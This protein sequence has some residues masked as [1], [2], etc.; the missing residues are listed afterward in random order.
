MNEHTPL[1][2]YLRLIFAIGFAMAGAEARGRELVKP[3]D[4]EEWYHETPNRVLF[5]LYRARFEHVLAG[6]SSEA[7]RAEVES[8]VGAVKEPRVKDRVEWLRTR[9]EW[10]RTRVVEPALVILKPWVE[11]ALAAIDGA[12]ASAPA[13]IADV[14]DDRKVFAY[15]KQRSVERTLRVVLRTGNDD[16]LE[17]VLRAIIMRLPKVDPPGQR[18]EVIGQC[19]RAAAML[20]DRDMV[21]RLLDELATLASAPSPNAP[22]PRDLF[23]AVIPGLA[24]LRK[25]GADASARRLLTT[26]EPFAERGQREGVKIRAALAD[27]YLIVGDQKRA[28]TL[29]ADCVDDVL[30]AKLDHPGRYEVCV[31][32]LAT[33]RSWPLSARLPLCE[34]IATNLDRFTDT[35]TSSIQKVYETYKILV[36]ERLVDGVIAP[37]D[38][39]TAFVEA[40]RDAFLDS[41][42]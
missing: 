18:A 4:A 13:L 32:I 21:D 25:L 37:G 41:A 23:Y 30:E 38:D 19:V 24:A 2:A 15:E 16:L 12:P 9:S 42:R 35:F 3:L 1:G 33:L 39:E 34:R 11:R 26:L 22:S 27:G 8:T 7:W 20:G 14:L 28:D 17:D 10:L 6:G 29:I 31:L 40:Q 5:K 36:A